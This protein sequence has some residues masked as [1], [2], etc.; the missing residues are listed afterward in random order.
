M[1]ETNTSY[2]V[3]HEIGT[4]AAAR[5]EEHA[6]E[7]CTRERQ[8]IELANQPTILALRSKIGVLKDT[9]D[10][11]E[12][13][14]PRATP[15]CE[16]RSR[17]KKTT[18]FWSI[19]A[20]LSIA[21]FVFAV[22]AFEPFRMGWKAWLYCVG[23]AVVT[24]FLVDQVLDSWPNPNLIRTVRT[25]AC[26]AAILS[27]ILLAVIRGDLFKQ[28]IG[29]D[30]PVITVN[31]DDSSTAASP[32]A[33]TPPPTEENFY[34]RTLGL[35]RLA[36]ALLAFAMELGAGLAAHEARRWSSSGEDSET[37][38]KELMAVTGRDDRARSQPVA[39]RK[40]RRDL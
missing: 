39:A 15:P 11:I 37:L 21:G 1:N 19:A 29:Q 9:A 30:D 20:L 36:M 6:T 27:G 10:D 40:R 3:G 31:S 24:P 33:T 12:S 4:G 7:Y 28:E 2:G 16:A 22:I 38:R 5:T 26:I 34:D 25:A 14:I 35:L 18:L 8:R 23:I 17:T 13:R 32:A